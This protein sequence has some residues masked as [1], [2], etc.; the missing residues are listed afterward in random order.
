MQH[1]LHRFLF[2]YALFAENLAH[3]FEG[4]K[5]GDDEEDSDH[6]EVEHVEDF[7]VLPRLDNILIILLAVDGQK[8][9]YR[10]WVG[11]D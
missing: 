9:T 11:H 5:R 7:V 10:D 1:K 6:D 8:H 2:F 3:V 4:K